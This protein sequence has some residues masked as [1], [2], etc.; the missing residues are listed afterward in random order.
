MY[1]LPLVGMLCTYKADGKS[2]LVIA[3]H[4]AVQNFNELPDRYTRILARSYVSPRS[5]MDPTFLP[6]N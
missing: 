5:Y 6:R 1:L 2:V 4:V 3:I